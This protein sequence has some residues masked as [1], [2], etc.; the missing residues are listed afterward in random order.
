MTHIYSLKL[1]SDDFCPKGPFDE[2]CYSVS[3]CC[4][5][6]VTQVMLQISALYD[7]KHA[8]DVP[9]EKTFSDTNFVRKSLKF[10]VRLPVCGLPT[11]SP[12]RAL[13]HFRRTSPRLSA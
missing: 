6:V 2:V 7:E 13:N 1:I 3:R 9:A 4:V 10:W 12:R 11:L 5:D 8:R